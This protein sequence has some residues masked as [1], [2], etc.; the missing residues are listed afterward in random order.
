MKASRVSGCPRSFPSDG[1]QIP[2]QCFLEQRAAAARRITPEQ[3]APV[4]FQFYFGVIGAVSAPSAVRICRK[5]GSRCTWR[6]ADPFLITRDQILH[7]HMCPHVG[8]NRLRLCDDVTA[9][10]MTW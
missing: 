3:A 7:M 6:K 2:V 1:H 10:A 8:D 5:T 4:V 9:D